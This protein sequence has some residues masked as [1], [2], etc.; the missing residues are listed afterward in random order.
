MR[1]KRATC[2]ICFKT[3]LISNLKRHRMVHEKKNERND[4]LKSELK[5]IEPIDSTHFNTNHLFEET[6]GR[7]SMVS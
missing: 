4:S 1:G 7:I 6:H 3:M 5:F 2:S